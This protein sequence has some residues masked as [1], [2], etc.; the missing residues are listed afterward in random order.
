MAAGLLDGELEAAVFGSGGG[1]FGDAQFLVAEAHDAVVIQ[2]LGAVDCEEV[3]ELGEELLGADVDGELVAHV[4][5]L[6]ELE[7]AAV[8]G[9]VDNHDAVH[10]VT[11]RHIG[12]VEGLAFGPFIADKGSEGLDDMV[13]VASQ[14]LGD[15]VRLRL[16]K[17]T[18][19]R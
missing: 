11:G 9:G 7:G 13:R 8:V 19:G 16:R 15:V 17:E 2:V 14:L 12:D 4:V 10:A 3:V 5:L 6:V 1:S 18:G